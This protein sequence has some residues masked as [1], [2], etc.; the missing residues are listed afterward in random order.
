MLST[1]AAWI[2]T[3]ALAG[4][5]VYGA[6]PPAPQT[7]KA[8]QAQPGQE[9]KEAAKKTAP[10]G[11]HIRRKEPKAPAHTEVF[12]REQLESSGRPGTGDALNLIPGTSK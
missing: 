1:R 9:K 10:T 2:L 12:T 7:A 4:A 11:S 6:E 5:P 8:E 3:A